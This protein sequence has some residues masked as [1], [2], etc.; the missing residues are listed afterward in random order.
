MYGRE[1]SYVWSI[2]CASVVNRV[3]ACMVNRASMYG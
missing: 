3:C 2:G 1:G